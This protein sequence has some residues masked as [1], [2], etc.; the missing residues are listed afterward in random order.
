[1]LFLIYIYFRYLV[2]YTK[3]IFS[4]LSKIL[5]LQVFNF[6][7]KEKNYYPLGKKNVPFL[8]CFT[9]LS[10]S[11]VFYFL[12]KCSELPLFT[13]SPAAPSLFNLLIL[14]ERG[15]QLINLVIPRALLPV[16]PF[17][18]LSLTLESTGCAQ[19]LQVSSQLPS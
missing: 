1:M 9:S 19:P 8:I 6:C 11:L 10:H 14:V 15:S 16:F 2:L 18:D 7:H 17:L 3:V 5:V 4:V 13:P 12:S